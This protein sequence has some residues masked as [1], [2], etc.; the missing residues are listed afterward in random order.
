MFI[1]GHAPPRLPQLLLSMLILVRQPTSW[2]LAV[3]AVSAHPNRPPR[4]PECSNGCPGCWW[5]PQ[6]YSGTA[7]RSLP[8]RTDGDRA[9][10]VGGN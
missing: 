4:G 7:A 1:F 3:Y 6:K 9:Q 10:R 8:T 2:E 5:T